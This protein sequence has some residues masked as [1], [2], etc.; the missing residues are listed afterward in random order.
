M[1][2]ITPFYLFLFFMAMSL[3]TY[4]QV[5]IV[6][7]DLVWSD[8]FNTNG[9][10]NPSN[11]HHQTQLPAGGSWFNGEVQHYTNQ[12]A[13]SSVNAGFL[14]IK[15]IKDPFTDQGVTKQYTSARLNSKFAFLYGRVDVRAKI[16]VTQ[17]TWPAIWLLGKNVN[18]D[19][20]FFDAQFGTTD[21]P[22]CGEIDMME[23]G[24]TSNQPT[25]Y[26]QSALHT[27]S[28][29]GN[30]MNIG[31][32]IATDLV[33]N[34]H[35]YSMNWSPFQITFLLD[36][37]AYYTYNPAVKNASNWP[38][39]AEQYILLNIAMGG[40]A[41]TIPAN[42]TEASMEVDYVRVYQNT[43]VDTESPTNFTASLAAVTG[44]T[45][46]LL[47]NGNDN[48]G[49]ILYT[50]NYGSTTITVAG[51]SGVQKSVVIPNLLSST[52]YVFTITAADLAGNNF[53]NN[54]LVVNATT[55]ISLDCSGTDSEAQQG[56]FT[57]GYNYKF[58]TIGT[59]VKITFEMLDTAPT[60]VIA[61]LWKQSPFYESQMT[62]VSGKKFTK[63][64]TG[65][66]I[67]TTINYAVKFAFAGGLAVTKYFSYVVG[68][69]CSL[70]ISNPLKPNVITFKNP[71]KYF[72]EIQ[73]ELQIDKVEIHSITG[74][75]MKSTTKNLS[76]ID[77][78]N[79]S[80]G[81]Y[82]VSI[83]S[84]NEKSVKKLVVE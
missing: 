13:N 21:W 35:V 9:A 72:I 34:F 28:S 38:F 52:A 1:K 5:D 59:D 79:L 19:G 11:W 42:F 76:K 58:E 23:H 29:F 41:G 78:S 46:E 40:I 64:I 73:S 6:Y 43:V 62:N 30:T 32:I 50:I 75:I 80:S 60:G 44:S 24:I 54:P 57:T 71:A 26:V 16:P 74:S 56:S 65:Q 82:I 33:N 31:G 67:G 53:V 69:D 61:Y 70:S 17:G 12:I 83:Y 20:G 2:K 66:T 47:L 63:T 3:N 39:N 7:S 36:G 25:N 10:V 81:I 37:V 8:E 55:T 15:A 27:P 49:T 77:I 48:S 51:T 4:S 68:N 22:A 45:V 84:E 14:N 18:E